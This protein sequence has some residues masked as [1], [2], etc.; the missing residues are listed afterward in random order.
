M[1]S[2]GFNGSFRIGPPLSSGPAAALF[3][4]GWLALFLLFRA[5]DVPLALGTLLQGGPP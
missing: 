4:G 2:R 1:L 5:V 3:T